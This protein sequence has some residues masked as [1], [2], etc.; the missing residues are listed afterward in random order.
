MIDWLLKFGPIAGALTLGGT[1]LGIFS[2][3]DT[4]F[5]DDAKKDITAWIRGRHGWDG[6]Q[7]SIKQAYT[8]AFG[9]TIFSFSGFFRSSIASTLCVIFLSILYVIGHPK[10]WDDAAYAGSIEWDGRAKYFFMMLFFVNIPSDYIC[11]ILSRG[12][13]SIEPKLPISL[14]ILGY[15]TFGFCCVIT[16]LALIAFVDS[17][18]YLGGDEDRTLNLT[19]FRSVT[20]LLSLSNDFYYLK[21]GL[22]W[23]PVIQWGGVSATPLYEVF[24]YG[25]FLYSGLLVLAWVGI[26]LAAGLLIRVLRKFERF[27]QIW[28]RYFDVDKYPLKCIGAIAAGLLGVGYFIAS[29]L[30]ALL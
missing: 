25:P 15:V 4:H 24:S 20:D 11:V 16:Y 28:L 26:Y 1:V 8:V 10:F 18:L 5:S 17:Q 13:I 30:T 6:F 19:G 7:N 21:G 29:G 27:W 2:W 23:E 9:K 3:L 12:F 22:L 14:K